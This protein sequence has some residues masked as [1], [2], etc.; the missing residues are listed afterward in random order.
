MRA[1][2]L[3]R[4][5]ERRLGLAPGGWTCAGVAI[6]LVFL[7]AGPR[8][9]LVDSF[10]LPPLSAILARASQ[11]LVEPTFWYRYLGPSLLAILLAFALAAVGGIII[12]LIL[13][14]FAPIR[15][16]FDPWLSIYYAIP[17]FALYPLLVV[18]AGIGLVP[19]I[20]LG[21]LLGIVSVITSTLDGLD[22]IPRITIKLARSLQLSTLDHVLKILMP[23]IVNQIVV[24]L[25]LALSFSIIGVMASEFIL[26]TYG[27]GYFISY[28]YDHFSVNDMY[29]GI[30]IVLFFALGVNF[31]FGLLLRG[32]GKRV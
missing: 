19:V 7:E 26:S 16:I 1:S 28:A 12:G 11:L 27:L 21:A 2:V 9:G 17:T 31:L 8:S 29:A 20:L 5:P 3:Q 13:W 15:G 4:H 10:T 30:V 6:I 23:S 25:R 18:V 14:R 24:G 22:S 32:R